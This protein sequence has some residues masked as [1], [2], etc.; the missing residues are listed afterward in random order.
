M[1]V[2]RSVLENSCC[3]LLM[4]DIL[5]SALPCTPHPNGEGNNT[6]GLASVLL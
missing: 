3:H 4:I 6:E 5:L 2:T 1:A